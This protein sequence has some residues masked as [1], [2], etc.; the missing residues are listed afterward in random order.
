METGTKNLK[1]NRAGILKIVNFR[2]ADSSGNSSGEI[3]EMNQ[4]KLSISPI[5]QS[6]AVPS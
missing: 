2:N 4:M 1:N 6:L 3:E 5:F